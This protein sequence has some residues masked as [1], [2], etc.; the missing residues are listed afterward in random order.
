[1]SMVSKSRLS[2]W[3]LVQR[4]VLTGRVHHLVFLLIGDLFQ[5]V[6]QFTDQFFITLGYCDRDIEHPQNPKTQQFLSRF[7]A[8]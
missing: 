6:I 3:S 8:S 5:R 7:Q 2:V 1:M 4:L